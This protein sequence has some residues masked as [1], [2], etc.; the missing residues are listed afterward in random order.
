MAFLSQLWNNPERT[1]EISLPKKLMASRQRQKHPCGPFE[2][3]I[4]SLAK[5]LNGKMLD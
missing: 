2:R 5:L 1:A 4:V 3:E